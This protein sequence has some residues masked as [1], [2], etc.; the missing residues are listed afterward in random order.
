MENNLCCHLSALPRL[1]V[2]NTDLETCSPVVF[3]WKILYTLLLQ[4]C[5]WSSCRPHTSQEQ[6]ESPASFWTGLE[7]S[8][9]CICPAAPSQRSPQSYS[10]ASA[11]GINLIWGVQGPS[12][13]IQ[14]GFSL[15]RTLHI[16]CSLP[17]RVFSF[18]D[19]KPFKWNFR[20]VWKAGCQVCQQSC[21]YLL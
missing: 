16:T 11:L 19:F 21:K 3:Q 7:F 18:W 5:Y 2:C 17:G 9:L 15:P 13:A 6:Q 20:E 1:L 12:Q 4:H 10:S 14:A 8:K